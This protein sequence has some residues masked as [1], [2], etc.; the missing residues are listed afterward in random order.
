MLVG[1]DMIFTKSIK[2]LKAFNAVLDQAI[3]L[4]ENIAFNQA[5]MSAPLLTTPEQAHETQQL[6][7]ANTIQRKRKLV[8]ERGDASIPNLPPVLR[9]EPLPTSPLLVVPTELQTRSPSFLSRAYSAVGSMMATAVTIVAG[10]PPVAGPTFISCR[11]EGAL[12]V[13]SMS[14]ESYCTCGTL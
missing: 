6:T 13:C 10:S 4:R 3:R 7:L 11:G 14:I 5:I 8:E 1:A 2:H 9:A 12:D